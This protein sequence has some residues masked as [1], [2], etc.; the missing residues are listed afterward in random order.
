ML[1]QHH[2]LSDAASETKSGPESARQAFKDAKHDHREAG[3][4][5]DAGKQ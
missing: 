5:F 2:S 4:E 1:N 3:G